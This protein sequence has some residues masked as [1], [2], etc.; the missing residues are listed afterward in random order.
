MPNIKSAKKR[1]LVTKTKT[2]HNQMFKT[3]MK[4]TVKKF[5][6]A[7]EAGN[8]EVAT[9]AYLDAVKKV[10]QAVAKGIIHKNNAGRKKSQFTLMLNNLD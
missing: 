4:T 5:K 1:V 2:L 7:I 8:K 9:A 3:S 10:D 6:A